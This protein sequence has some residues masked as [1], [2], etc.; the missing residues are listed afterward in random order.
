[1]EVIKR[2]SSSKTG[3]GSLSDHPEEDEGARIVE[4]IKAHTYGLEFTNTN[5]LFVFIDKINKD[6]VLNTYKFEENKKVAQEGGSVA[7]VARKKLEE[8]IGKTVI[9]NKR[10]MLG[11]GKRALK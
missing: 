2:D 7:G 8:K 1:M 3:G 10:H 11:G 9:S 6:D 4:G 5:D